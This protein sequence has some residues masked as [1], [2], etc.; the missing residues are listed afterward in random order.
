[1]Q[2]TEAG[3]GEHKVYR[4]YGAPSPD[5]A[6]LTANNHYLGV[7][8]VAWAVNKEDSFF[9]DRMAAG[10]ME[11]VL[12]S[13][14]ESFQVA[15]GSFQIKGGAKIAPV[16]GQPVLPDRSYRGG[17]LQFTAFLTVTRKDSAIASLLKGAADASL[18]VVAG[19]VQTASLTGP[20]LALSGAG[21]ALVGGVRTML[22]DSNPHQEPLFDFSGLRFALQ[23]SDFVGPELYLLL[24]RGALLDE[25]QLT[26][27]K[28]GETYLPMWRGKLLEDGAW[29]LL[30]LR[31]SD[32]YSGV[33]Q[34]YEEARAVRAAIDDVVADARSELITK[35][36]A[37]AQLTPSTTG[38]KTVADKYLRLRDVISRDGVL[39]ER[40]A[41]GHVTQLRV[42]FEAAR[43][44][45]AGQAQ[46]KY[47]DTISKILSQLRQGDIVPGSLGNAVLEEAQSM[48]AMR[49]QATIPDTLLRRVGARTPSDVFASMKFIPGVHERYA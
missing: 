33:R 2:G 46:G 40:E 5:I 12:A 36:Q 28:V 3:K 1:M 20:A 23:P 18:G 9:S 31:R 34:W 4:V 13:G 7:D 38:D 43:A 6:K 24:H 49:S 47:E 25:T 11:I 27:S 48:A 8:A 41:R 39:C 44:A 42:R 26:V 22:K 45:V 37:L 30:R 35:D 17:P 16:F 29:L 21:A 10:T 15:L 32:E 14:E 19:M